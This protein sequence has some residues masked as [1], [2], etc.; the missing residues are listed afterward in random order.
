MRKCRIGT[1]KFFTLLLLL[2]HTQ[3]KLQGFSPEVSEFLETFFKLYPT[4]TDK[5]LSY[6]VKGHTL[7]TISGDSVF[8]ELQNPVYTMSGE[9]VKVSVTVKYLDN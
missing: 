3:A 4:A 9:Q 5:D 7:T 2:Y 8:S 1:A 6:Y